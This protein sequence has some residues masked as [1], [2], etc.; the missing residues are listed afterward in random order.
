[1]TA[2]FLQS[3]ME[4]NSEDIETKS[5]YVKQECKMRSVDDSTMIVAELL[6]GMASSKAEPPLDAQHSAPIAQVPACM[7]D[8]ISTRYTDDTERA[9]IKAETNVRWIG[10]C[11]P[12]ARRQKIERYLE[13]RKRRVW[14][15]KV[16][17]KVRK[18]F[19]DSRLR[20]KGRFLK[21]TDEIRLREQLVL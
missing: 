7:H 14:A 2:Q 9:P 8:S 10:K 18:N 3:S 21:K 16:D 12:E 13:K 15:K 4:S 20:Y 6:A 5:S 11:S 17:Y 19:A 1:M